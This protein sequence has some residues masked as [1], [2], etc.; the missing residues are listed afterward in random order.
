[1]NYFFL[2]IDG[3]IYKN[4]TL[5]KKMLNYL[6]NNNVSYI[7]CT[8]RGYLRCMDI[9]NNYIDDKSLII[10]ENGSKIVT[11]NNKLIYYKCL[12][13]KDKKS[14]LW[15]NQNQIDYIL[16]NTLDSDFYFEFGNNLLPFVNKRNYNYE[17]FYKKVLTNDICQITIK[18]INKTYEKE[19]YQKCKNNNINIIKSEDYII[20]NAFGVNKKTAIEYIINLQ[21]INMN[22]V[23]VFGNDY[24]D[25]EMFKMK[26]ANKVL[27]KEKNTPEILLKLA[28]IITSYEE[29]NTVVSE[30]VESNN[31]KSKS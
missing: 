18:F 8:G 15:I 2:D 7:F 23:S 22:N 25:I 9:V 5:N 4:D 21:N 20:L 17:E 24:N 16:F 1:M 28:N 29:L 27:I 14:L 19:F 13:E 26:I 11:G 3:V 6:K 31:L 30:I 12:N 10:I